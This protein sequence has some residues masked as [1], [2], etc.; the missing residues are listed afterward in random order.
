[1]RLRSNF[2]SVAILFACA[3]VMLAQAPTATIRGVVV[4]P[5]QAAVPGAKVTI[6]QTATGVTR[7]ALTGDLGDYRFPALAPGAYSIKA[8]AAGFRA[9]TSSIELLVGREATMNLSL[10]IEAGRQTVAV[11]AQAAQ[12]NTTEYKVEGVISHQQIENMPLN[13]RNALELAR[14]Q[15]GVLVTSGVPSGKNGFVSV[16][17]GGET[18]AATRV[19]VDG[20]SVND[21]VT[22]GTWQNFSQE[23]VQEFQ[24]STGNFDP[25]TGITAAGAV[26]MI[27][28]SGSNAFHGTGFGYWRDSSFAA[29][30]SL[31]RNPLVPNP[32]FDREQ[33]GY[34]LS[35]PVIHDHLFW[36]SSIDRTRQRGVSPFNANNT[37]LMSFNVIKKE[38]FDVML[39]T[40]KVDWN[41]ND[42]HH[43]SLRYSRDGN[44]GQAGGGLPDNQ[45][46]NQNSADQYLLNWTY[47]L[48][49]RLVN[50]FR[51]QFNKYSNYYKPT[52]EALAA[53]IP[54]YSVLQSNLSF[55]IDNNSPQSTLQGRLEMN[56]N[57]SQQKDRHSL[58][59]GFSLER[60]RGRGSWQYRYPASVSL[61]SPAQAR[62]AGISVPA[63]FTT[64]QDVLQLP[65]QGF[66]FGVGN[67]Q[68]PP[69]H[70]EAASVNHRVRFYAGDSWKI[71]KSLTLNFALSYS[72]EDNLVST[73]LPKPASLSKILNGN[74]QPTRRDWN[75]IAPMVGFAWAPGNNPKTVIRGGFG[76]YYDTLLAN[77]RLVE[78]TYLAPYGVG[79]AV[80]SQD[81]VPDPRNPK[82]TLSSLVKGP[83]SFRGSDFLSYLPIFTAPLQ[84]QMAANQ[85]NEDLSFTNLDASKGGAGILDPFLTTPYSMQYSLGIQRELPW[86]ILLSADGQVKQTVHEIFSADYN[87]NNHVGGNVDPKLNAVGFYQTGGTAQYKAL[88]VRAEKRYAKRYQFMASYALTSFVGLNGSGLFLGSSASNNDNWKDA[89][90]P[91]GSDKRHRLVGAFSVDAPWGFQFSFISEAT[92]RGPANLTAGNYDY[93]GDGT[94]GDRYPGIGANQVYRS[95]SISDIPA[96]VAQFNAQY[97]GTKDAQGATIKALPPLPANYALGDSIISQ[98]VRV[99]K[100]FRIKERFRINAIGEVFNAF[101]IANLGGF[102]GDLSS[103][104]FGQPT[105][106]ISSVFGS[107]GP[108]AFQFALRASF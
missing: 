69:Y 23:I 44:Q 4:D 7:T 6:E 2:F 37:E 96:L 18:S 82:A 26:N 24:V 89:F 1:M 61:Y 74:L 93:N 77:V 86:N 83:S 88:L 87:K 53:G 81:V 59:Y 35:G 13:G 107:G 65:V 101:N 3:L 16:G 92:S 48:G 105:S 54:N 71:T 79:Y 64:L 84:A 67:P 38:P 78:R 58:K 91:Q 57:F 49:P 100:V 104:T 19:T 21:S 36:L 52:P 63:T 106:R 66:T 47:I 27:T 98:D 43:V 80:M 8:E 68:Q 102:S 30:P 29:N 11:E 39:Q 20:G 62:A 31:A 76:I 9:A 90:G 51:I 25:S 46:I 22:G 42:A 33:Y 99:T 32:K 72:F 45:R 28:R 97:A 94:R 10:E 95:I 14:L 12:V 34:L 17:I 108:R 75:N 15:P 40:H 73:D 60:I 55:G 41:P 70:P 56:D 50:D 103:T 85:K 5:S